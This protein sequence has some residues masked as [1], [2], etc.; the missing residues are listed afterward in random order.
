MLKAFTSRAP[1]TLSAITSLEVRPL[2]SA[3]LKP[4]GMIGFMASITIRPFQGGRF[5]SA[6]AWC[7]HGTATRTMSAAAASSRVEAVTRRAEAARELRER[8][9]PAVVAD[10]GRHAC[11]GE[12]PRDGLSDVPRADDPDFHTC[13][14]PQQPR[15]CLLLLEIV[16]YRTVIEPGPTTRYLRSTHHCIAD[17][18]AFETHLDGDTG[19]LREVDERR[20]LLHPDRHLQVR[21]GAELGEDH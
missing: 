16:C 17:G 19:E 15:S 5:A 11:L 14:P 20:T 10:H 3:T 18:E 12:M 9:G 4:G 21:E 8:V 7:S 6:A 13:L 2:R 1:G